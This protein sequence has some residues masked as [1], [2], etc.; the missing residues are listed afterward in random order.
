M[1]LGGD[2]GAG[3]RVPGGIHFI[4]IVSIV[5]AWSFGGGVRGLRNRRHVVGRWVQR[6]LRNTPFKRVRWVS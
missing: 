3:L 6:Q 2:M 1:L 4:V 5:I